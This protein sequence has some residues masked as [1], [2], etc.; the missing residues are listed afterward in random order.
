M[1]WILDILWGFPGGL[2]GKESTCNVVDLG[3]I[4]ELGRS[5]GG[6]HGNS[7][8]YFCL[9]NLKD[10]WAWQATVHRVAKSRTRLSDWTEL[11]RHGL[12]PGQ[13]RSSG[14]GLGYPLQ[15]SCLDNPMDRG[16]WWATVHGVTESNTTEQ[17][18]HTHASIEILYQW[19]K[20]IMEIEMTIK[21]SMN[22][23]KI[24]KQLI[25]AQ[26]TFSSE[27]VFCE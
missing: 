1:A 11:K 8:H 2:D 19:V 22:M 12:V 14:E 4:P 6:G 20:L 25:V 13:R 24:K 27:N 10:R 18:T 17:L 26:I 16:A 23:Q 3:L 7:L 5:P 21:K 9:E 15:Y